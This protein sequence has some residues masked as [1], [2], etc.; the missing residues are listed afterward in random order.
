MR[1]FLGHPKGWDDE[2]IDLAVRELAADM[3]SSLEKAVE[4]IS[5]R[6]D[7]H[8]NIA[9]EGNF[10]GWCRSITRRT[11]QYGR[12]FYDVVAVPKVTMSGTVGKATAMIVRDA[13]QHGL[14]AVQV[15]WLETGGIEVRPVTAVED[16]DTEN[17]IAGWR[18]VTTDVT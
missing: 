15:E 11:D 1:V 6:D 9:A 10:N 8:A 2:T 18:L 7:F 4:V 14:P 13:L 17:Y 3:T 16:E 12:R 5:G